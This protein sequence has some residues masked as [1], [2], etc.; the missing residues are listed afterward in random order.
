MKHSLFGIFLLVLILGLEGFNPKEASAEQQS[1]L[2][3]YAISHGGSTGISPPLGATIDDQSFGGGT[4][5]ARLRFETAQDAGRLSLKVWRR[6]RSGEFVFALL[7]F[8]IDVRGYDDQGQ[9]V[10]STSPEPFSF[11]DSASGFW[12]ANLEDL[13]PDIQKIEIVF[14]GNYE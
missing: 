9:L 14:Y 8:Q 7:V 10:Y 11:G 3:M 12:S 4:A 1:I 2:E 13:P 5:K 6:V